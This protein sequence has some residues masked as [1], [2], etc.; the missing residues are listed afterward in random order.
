[1]SP[2]PYQPGSPVNPGRDDLA[3]LA[4]QP[5]RQPLVTPGQAS[6][7]SPI[8]SGAPPVVGSGNPLIDLRKLLFGG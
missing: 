1:V 4:A 6:G 3:A 2:N 8:L 7:S 5:G